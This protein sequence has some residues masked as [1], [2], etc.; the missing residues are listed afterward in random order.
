M[1]WKNFIKNTP[2]KM[3]KSQIKNIFGQLTDEGIQMENVKKADLLLYILKLESVI[4]HEVEW[5]KN[6]I[7]DIRDEI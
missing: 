5:G 3:R 2:S 4:L 1:N 6:I 7:K